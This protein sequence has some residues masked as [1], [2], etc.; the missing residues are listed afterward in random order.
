[1]SPLLFYLSPP[2]H[3][4]L[5]ISKNKFSFPASLPV[6]TNRRSA[7]C[8]CQKVT[9]KQ[10]HHVILL[11]CQ[12]CDIATLCNIGKYQSEPDDDVESSLA[13]RR[14]WRLRICPSLNA[15][16]QTRASLIA[17]SNSGL[18]IHACKWLYWTTDRPN[19][20]HVEIEAHQA[21]YVM[22]RKV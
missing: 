14:R 13:E 17:S 11:Q 10:R 16:T 18:I 8:Q 15:T 6:F 7:H 1:M 20:H 12:P 4:L 21:M 9:W 2:P 22:L 5:L 3:T 19:F